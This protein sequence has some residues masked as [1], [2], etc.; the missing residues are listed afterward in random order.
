MNIFCKIAIA[1]SV[2][3]SCSTSICKE[4]KVPASKSYPSLTNLRF[5]EF[6]EALLPCSFVVVKHDGRYAVRSK[7]SDL[8][9]K[10]KFKY[11]G[12]SVSIDKITYKITKII[13]RLKEERAGG[14][15]V[16]IDESLIFLES[17]DGKYKI[18]LQSGKDTYSPRPKAVIEDLRNHKK[19]LVGEGDTLIIASRVPSS[20]TKHNKVKKE[21]YKVIK[22]NR[23]KNLVI[24]EYM[25]KKYLIEKKN[26]SIQ[27]TTRIST[28]GS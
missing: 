21:K 23:I 2:V 24:V 16:K 18:T 12:D 14:T 26:K 8:I 9:G 15:V 1:L 6:R 5:I 20:K 10:P 25:N 27:T 22:F 13:P 4:E 28:S 17:E 7:Y 11:A 19:Y 3:L